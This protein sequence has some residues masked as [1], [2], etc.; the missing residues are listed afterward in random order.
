MVQ[1]DWTCNEDIEI[2]FYGSTP[3]VADGGSLVLI[4]CPGISPSG[5]NVYVNPVYTYT[6][7]TL[8][9][10]SAYSHSWDVVVNKGEGNMEG[11]IVLAAIIE[12]VGTSPFP[13]IKQCRCPLCHHLQTVKVGTTIIVCDNCGKTYFVQDFSRIR[14]L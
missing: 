1:K 14:G 8:D 11:R 3:S 12:A 6:S 4:A 13:D 10:T 7:L 5:D 2:W 9:P